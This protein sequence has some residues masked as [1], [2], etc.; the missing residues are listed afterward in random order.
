MLLFKKLGLIIKMSTSQ[1]LKTTFKYN[2][3]CIF[4]S[5]RTKLKKNTLPS[6]TLYHIDEAEKFFKKLTY[7]K[8]LLYVLLGLFSIF[9]RWKIE[10]MKVDIFYFSFGGKTWVVETFINRYAYLG[11]QVGLTSTLIRVSK[12]VADRNSHW[13][14]LF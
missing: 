14:I 10:E 6:D 11:Y 12:V 3:T 13:T 8:I 9:V 5:L 2:V 7:S 1:D 4:L